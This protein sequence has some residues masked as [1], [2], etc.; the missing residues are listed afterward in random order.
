MDTLV[1]KSLPSR[2]N[3][4][5][6]KRL[7]FYVDNDPGLTILFQ[8]IMQQSMKNCNKPIVKG[9]YNQSFDE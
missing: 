5:E 3:Q 2:V 7:D 8:A 1:D 6:A 9:G 4:P